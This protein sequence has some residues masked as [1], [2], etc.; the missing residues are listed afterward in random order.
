MTKFTAVLVRGSVPPILHST[1]TVWYCHWQSTSVLT[2]NWC[3]LK[4]K[5][6]PGMAQH[7]TVGLAS[8]VASDLLA[9]VT[10]MQ[11]CL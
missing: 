8:E 9:D 4:A 11:R 6:S 1:T 10:D 5:E 2:P 3:W 7:N